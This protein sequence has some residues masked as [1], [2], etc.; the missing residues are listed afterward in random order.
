M[1]VNALCATETHLNGA[2]F[3]DPYPSCPRCNGKALAFFPQ[4]NGKRTESR[5]LVIMGCGDVG[6]LNLRPTAQLEAFCL[7]QSWRRWIGVSLADSSQIDALGVVRS[8]LRWRIGQCAA[9]I[10]SILATQT[11]CP[12]LTVRSLRYREK[13]RAGERNQAAHRRGLSPQRHQA[14]QLDAGGGLCGAEW[15]AGQGLGLWNCKAVW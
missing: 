12:A 6:R 7:V 1:P 13:P 3:L 5:T 14:G 9:R 8:D 10:E 11:G 15:G 2:Y 4:N